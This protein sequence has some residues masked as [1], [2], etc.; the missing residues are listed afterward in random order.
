MDGG[1]G[2]GRAGAE[3]GRGW[4][5]DPRD[6]VQ[7]PPPPTGLF[8]AAP[9]RPE[10]DEEMARRLQAEWSAPAAPP[11]FPMEPVFTRSARDHRNR[12]AARFRR[13]GLRAC[14]GARERARAGVG[15]A[16][17]RC[18]VPRASLNR[19]PPPPTLGQG[20]PPLSRQPPPPRPA[21]RPRRWPRSRRP[22]PSPPPRASAARGA[23]GRRVAAAAPIAEALL[24]VGR[25]ARRR[26]AMASGCRRG[27]IGE[28]GGPTFKYR[29]GADPGQG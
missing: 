19:Q 16:L 18:S 3:A 4:A 12:A 8:A 10:T 23:V 9:S 20:P 17:R 29:T 21:C 7:P 24:V 2:P 25:R 15:G 28:D 11:T 27:V 26:R 22:R 14:A 1:P 5:P 6:V 13:G